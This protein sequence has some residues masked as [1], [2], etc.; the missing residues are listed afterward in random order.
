MPIEFLLEISVESDQLR[1]TFQ[2][3]VRLCYIMC[4]NSEVILK[5]N[6]VQ[7]YAYTS[8]I[9]SLENQV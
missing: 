5:K 7:V 6:D 4:Y 9:Q 2:T 1:Q 8:E 3:K